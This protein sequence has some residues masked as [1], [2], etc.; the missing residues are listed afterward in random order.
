MESVRRASPYA[1]AIEAAVLGQQYGVPCETLAPCFDDPDEPDV[2]D[3]LRRG[4]GTDDDG[5]KDES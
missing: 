2:L 3:Y 5:E 4:Y 1:G